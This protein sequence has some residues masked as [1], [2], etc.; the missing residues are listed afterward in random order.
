MLVWTRKFENLD[1]HRD[2]NNLT[3]LDYHTSSNRSHHTP[4]PIL[5]L[6]DID[7]IS[8]ART[9]VS[10]PE[11]TLPYQPLYKDA[12]FVALSDWSVIHLVIFL[13][14]WVAT[15]SLFLMVSN[16]YLR[17]WMDICRDGTIMT[18]DLN[19]CA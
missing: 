4:N 10:P 19:D 18:F 12:P 3:Q 7:Y 6:T 2:T 17:G 9:W 11:S 8:R 13:P 5:V 14:I 1:Q 16:S 15:Q